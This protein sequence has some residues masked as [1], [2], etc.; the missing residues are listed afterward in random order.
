VQR[1]YPKFRSGNT[2]LEDEPHGSRLLTID[3]D[4]LKELVE[5]DPHTT[6]RTLAEKLNIGPSTVTRHLKQIENSKKLDKWKPHKFTESHKIVVLNCLLHFFCATRM[7][8][9]SIG[10]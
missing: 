1:W 9:F 7:T 10:L 2:N 5:A 6:V 3:D 4:K 8:W